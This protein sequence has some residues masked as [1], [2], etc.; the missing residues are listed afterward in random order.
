[1]CVRVRGD[2]QI[3]GQQ[4]GRVKTLDLDSRAKMRRTPDVVFQPFS[5]WSARRVVRRGKQHE[6]QPKKYAASIVRAR[7]DASVRL[8]HMRRTS[9]VYVR[10]CAHAAEQSSPFYGDTAVNPWSEWSAR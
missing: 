2:G 3:E 9:P 5:Q 7:T 6:F 10:R 8:A 1:M 4:G